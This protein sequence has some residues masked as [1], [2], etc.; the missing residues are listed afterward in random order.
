MRYFRSLV[1]RSLK[2]HEEQD[3]G[4]GSLF[5]VGRGTQAQ[6]RPVSGGCGCGSPGGPCVLCSGGAGREWQAD[7]LVC[8][9]VLFEPWLWGTGLFW[10]K[11]SEPRLAEQPCGVAV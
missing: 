9:E 11:L 3:P 4:A 1:P 7:P 2:G 10:V 8:L 5:S 6:A